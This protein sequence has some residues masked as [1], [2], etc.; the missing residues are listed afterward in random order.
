M[1]VGEDRAGRRRR[2]DRAEHGVLDVGVLDGRLDDEGRVRD[3]VLDRRRLG[4][5]RSGPLVGLGVQPT[6]LVPAVEPILDPG[7]RSDQRGRVGIVQAHRVAGGDADLGDARAHRTRPDDRDAL[8]ETHG[9]TA[10]PRRAALLEERCHPLPLV[11]GLEERRERSALRGHAV[12]ERRLGS[13][14]DGALRRAHRARSVRR[15]RDRDPERLGDDLG[16]GDGSRREAGRDRF[17][18]A[19]PASRQDRSPS[20]PPARRRAAGA[21]CRRRPA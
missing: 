16:G 13:G 2:I 1:F 10:R 6:L 12:G 21:A 17:G 3:R 9:S 8:L 15:D 11:L 7:R 14:A 5:R 18:A 4:Q 20:R 19:E